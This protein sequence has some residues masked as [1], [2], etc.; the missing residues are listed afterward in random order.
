AAAFGLGAC[1]M[2]L[3][4]SVNLYG[5]ALA[6]LAAYGAWA[7]LDGGDPGTARLVAVGALAAM[8]VATEYETGIVFAVLAI[9]V[10]R[11]VRGR[12]AWF[13]LGALAPVVLAG[14]YQA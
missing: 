7:V 4:H 11:R 2:L 5:A 3:P 13:A 1:S 10:I 12:V 9:V 14:G 8:S 6:A